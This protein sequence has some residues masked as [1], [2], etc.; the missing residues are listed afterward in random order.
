MPVKFVFDIWQN[1]LVYWC[2]YNRESVLIRRR[3]YLRTR[4]KQYNILTQD[5]FVLLNWRDEVKQLIEERR[6]RVGHTVHQL[7]LVK[8]RAWR[9]S[10]IG[11]SSKRA[12][13]SFIA[14]VMY[15]DPHTLNHC[16]NCIF[17]SNPLFLLFYGCFRS[18]DFVDTNWIRCIIIM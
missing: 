12:F 6:L 1:K 18:D 9:I 7:L 10:I 3:V 13:R 4:L 11:T 5:A 2:A 17:R 14:T 8:K 15:L 16:L